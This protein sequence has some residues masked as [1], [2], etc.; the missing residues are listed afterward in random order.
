[1]RNIRTTALAVLAAVGLMT[2]GVAEARDKAEGWKNWSDRAEAIET[3]LHQPDQVSIK[4][5][6]SGVTGTIIG[7]GFQFP[8][9]AMGLMPTCQV[10]KD[11]WLYKGSRRGVK[12]WCS[13]LKDAGN[14]LGKAEPVAEAPNAAPIAL[15]L[16][17]TLLASYDEVCKK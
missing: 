16:S 13:D 17:A 15:R 3:A 12:R 1:M 9:W 14:Q 2:A 6:C 10:S 11:L 5:A 4:T 8:R 7:Q